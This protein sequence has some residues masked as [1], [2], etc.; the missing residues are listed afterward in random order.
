VSRRQVRPRANLKGRTYPAEFGARHPVVYNSLLQYFFSD[1]DR[2]WADI[3]PER[4]V[5]DQHL[6]PH[7][8]SQFRLYE[9]PSRVGMTVLE[10][11]LSAEHARRKRI[12]WNKHDVARLKN[13]IQTE[14]DRLEFDDGETHLIG[15]NGFMNVELTT[16][17]R[18]GDAD[19]RGGGR[20]VAAIVNQSSRCAELFVQEHE[21]ITKGLGLNLRGFRYPYEEYVPKMTMGRVFKEVG[22]DKLDAC[23]HAAQN[24]LP[25]VVAV[26]PLQF[27]AQQEIS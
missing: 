6:R 23:I 22:P 2:A 12:Q 10:K 3:I 13:E 5:T 21:I 27:F 7:W 25:I 1:L 26:E 4:E 20:K 18:V 16:I 24:L 15:S 9:D 14:I 8:H 17:V 11:R 19:R